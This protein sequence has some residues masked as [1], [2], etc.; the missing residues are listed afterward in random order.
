[1]SEPVKKIKQTPESYTPKN[2]PEILN[3]VEDAQQIEK[4]VRTIN[5]NGIMFEIVERTDVLW[6]GCLDYAN[7]NKDESDSNITLNRYQKYLDVVKQDLINPD[8]S[9]SLWVNYG[10]DDKPYGQMF[11]Q[12]TYS[13]KQDERYET[14]TQPGGL[15]I[16]VR[17]KKETSLVLFG[18]ENIDAWDYFINKVLQNAAEE[19]GYN[20]NPDV[21][22]RI[23]YDC[24]AEYNTPPHA[25]YVYMPVIENPE[26]Y[27]PKNKPVIL[28]MVSE[29]SVAN[30]PEITTAS[31]IKAK[32]RNMVRIMELPACKMVTSGPA[33]GEF[34]AAD[35]NDICS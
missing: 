5:Y 15:W 26:S 12:E 9:A 2:K 24:H 32:E 3:M 13:A 14:F 17:R 8:W 28:E 21:H 1:M 25:C 33:N 30:K 20:V 35:H 29:A 11:A 10:C 6:V 16:R 18:N 31:T 23:G 19:N 34:N 4:L 7:N 27:S 22:V